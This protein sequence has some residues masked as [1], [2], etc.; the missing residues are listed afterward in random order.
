MDHRLSI[1]P[2]NRPLH[3]HLTMQNP[4]SGFARNLNPTPPSYT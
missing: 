1:S 2:S 4:P 3:V